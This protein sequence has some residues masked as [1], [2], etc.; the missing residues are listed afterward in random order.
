[1]LRYLLTSWVLHR[2]GDQVTSVELKMGVAFLAGEEDGHA[3]FDAE[4]GGSIFWEGHPKATL[5]ILDFSRLDDR[6]S[7]FVGHR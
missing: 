3:G 1:M 7:E 2:L 4:I 5:A 6:V